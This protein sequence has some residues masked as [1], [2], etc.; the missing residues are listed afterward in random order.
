M[1]CLWQRPPNPHAEHRHTL[2]RAQGLKQQDE[3]LQGYHP[4]QMKSATE[5]DKKHKGVLVAGMLYSVEAIIFKK[6][7]GY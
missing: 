4:W 3:L 2:G 5:N 1:P 7:H 6:F